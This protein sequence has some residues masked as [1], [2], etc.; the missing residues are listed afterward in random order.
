VVVKSASTS[1]DTPPPCW[2]GRSELERGPLRLGW[3][4]RRVRKGLIRVGGLSK[5]TADKAPW[6]SSKTRMD[7]K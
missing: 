7:Q 6:K 4:K 3:V 5:V 1:L 2:T